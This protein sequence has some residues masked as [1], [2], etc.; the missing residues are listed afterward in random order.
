MRLLLKKRVDSLLLLT[1][2]TVC[3][4]ECVRYL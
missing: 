4:R 2:Y 3:V 1:I